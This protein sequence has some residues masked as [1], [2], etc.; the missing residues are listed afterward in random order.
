MGSS[1]ALG[2][3]RV[4]YFPGRVEY[5]SG[6]SDGYVDDIYLP[7]PYGAIDLRIQ[8]NGPDDVTNITPLQTLFLLTAGSHHKVILAPLLTES[9]VSYDS[10][11]SVP[12]RILQL[13]AQ[14]S[15]FCFPEVP[16]NIQKVTAV[17]RIAGVSEGSYSP[18]SGVNLLSAAEAAIS[19]IAAVR[20][21]DSST[22]FIDL[23][24]QWSQLRDIYSGDFKSHYI[25][26]AFVAAQGY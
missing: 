4:T 1:S 11:A 23:G 9:L 22:Y 17:L 21:A 26:R 8:V 5:E 7:T 10:S 20:H 19:K 13:K 12:E 2:L 14:I 24:N 18:P 15:Q 3:Y 6:G 16:S 25:V